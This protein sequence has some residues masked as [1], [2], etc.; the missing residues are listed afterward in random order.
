MIFTSTKYLNGN[1][2]WNIGVQHLEGED[3]PQPDIEHKYFVKFYYKNKY[4]VKGGN[5]SLEF[6]L[7][8]PIPG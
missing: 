3:W 4:P 2:T 1:I 8:K 6:L 7:Q 5:Q